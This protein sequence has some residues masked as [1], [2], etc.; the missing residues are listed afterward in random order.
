M[1]KQLSTPDHPD[2]TNRDKQEFCNQ[3]QDTLMAQ[4]PYANKEELKT[5]QELFSATLSST[6][7]VDMEFDDDPLTTCKV[8]SG[9]N[10]E[11][12]DM[13][14]C[15]KLKSLDDLGVYKLVPHSSVPHG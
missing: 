7:P 1:R 10:A 9:N 8:L 15:D 12:W 2:T 5:L 6:I 3:I 11:Q 4:M 14:I 13:G